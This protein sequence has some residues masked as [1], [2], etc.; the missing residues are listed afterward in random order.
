MPLFITTNPIS[1]ILT[2][3]ATCGG[4]SILGTVTGSITAKGVCWSTSANPTT[5]LSTKTNNGTGSSNFT[6]SLISLTSGT[7]YYVRAYVTDNSGTYYGQN[8]V[9]TTL[10]LTT[11][12]A[13][14]I[15][16]TTAI[17]GATSVNGF[18]SISAVG[19]C[20]NTSTSPTISNNITSDILIGNSFT[21]NITGLLAETT[22]YVR[23]YV[24]SNGVTYY[25]SQI[26]FTTL[27]TN[28]V[29]TTNS[30]ITNISLNG[31]SVSGNVTSSGG[32]SVTSRGI[33]W[34]LFSTMNSS[35]NVPS[36]NGTG[37][38]TSVITGLSNGT[39]YY[40]QAYATN[41]NGTS[42]GAIYNFTTLG[43]ATIETITPY[44]IKASS[45][46]SGC[47]IINLNG[48]SIIERGICIGIYPNPTITNSLVVLDAYPGNTNN[49]LVLLQNLTPGTTYHIRAYA[50]TNI[51]NT[52]LT[53]YG[54]NKSF[55]TVYCEES[56]ITINNT[57]ECNEPVCEYNIPS[58]CV[59]FD[60]N[61]TCSTPYYTN[62]THDV[63]VNV[64]DSEKVEN[65]NLN[66][67]YTNLNNQFC[68]IYSKAFIKE[69]LTLIKNNEELKI[70]FCQ[71]KSDC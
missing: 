51:S 32:S 18:T 60:K 5:A 58:G 66:E 39:T 42:Y 27:S 6:S 71:I 24:T 7:T 2:T 47:K 65:N 55:D 50:K 25:G 14:S 35:T 13:T 54:D 67:I 57:I 22:Y 21:S 45:A 31:A 43:G 37:T 68:Y 36:G 29:V 33:R 38:F 30:N 69:F 12:A 11:T 17:S 53:A 20:W 64:N 8:V 46:I 34:S 15:T 62:V 16:S 59:Y 9:F 28:P 19:V 56:C 48:G 40:V 26:T 1:S 3:T 52:T 63:I 61:I 70:I 41:N 4:N 10:G 49:Y 44:S 23:S